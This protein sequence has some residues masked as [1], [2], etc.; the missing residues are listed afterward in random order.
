MEI[1]AAK[2]SCY[3]DNDGKPGFDCVIKHS[4]GKTSELLDQ[5]AAT[6]NIKD[7]KFDIDFPG[8]CESANGEIECHID[9]MRDR[10]ISIHPKTHKL[11]I[12]KVV[13]DG[14]AQR[15]FKWFVRYQNECVKQKVKPGMTQEDIQKVVADC[16]KMTRNKHM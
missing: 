2:V 11:F 13:R 14:A 10:V 3:E 4:N 9:G 1:N 12:K 15:A 8:I 6:F 7:T 16:S 5:T